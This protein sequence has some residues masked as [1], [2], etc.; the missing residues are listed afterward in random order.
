M[1]LDGAHDNGLRLIG[2]GMVG[3]KFI[4]CCDIADVA[5][6]LMRMCINDS[7]KT[8]L[9]DNADGPYDKELWGA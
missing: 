6:E 5:D 8:W 2:D 9:A 3:Y 1:I 7:H 4:P